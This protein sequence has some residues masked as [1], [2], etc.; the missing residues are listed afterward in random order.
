MLHKSCSH[1][2]AKSQTRL[3]LHNN[4]NGFIAG[5]ACMHKLQQN[6]F[7]M[8]NCLAEESSSAP[9]AFYLLLQF[10]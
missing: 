3:S 5:A 8:T 9:H 2:Q 4:N 6:T 7:K 1:E 10:E